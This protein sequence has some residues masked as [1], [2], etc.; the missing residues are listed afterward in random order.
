MKQ[1]QPASRYCF[2]CGRENPVGLKLDFYAVS[3]EEVI[4]EYIVPVKYQG[5]PG[6][7]HGGIIAA[8]LDEVTGRVFMHG[9]PPRFMYT[10]KLSIRYRKPVPVGHKLKLVGHAGKD[11]GRVAYATGEIFDT[12][13]NLLADA[14]AVYVNV[15]EET[16][17]GVNLDDLGWKVYPDEETVE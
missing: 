3:P 1:K 13:G 10:A 14:E 9:D 7:V 16:L 2:V 11:N 12:S 6:V 4:S 17:A 8:M 15:P 5:Y